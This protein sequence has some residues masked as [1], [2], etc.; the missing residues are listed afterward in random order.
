MVVERCLIGAPSFCPNAVTYFYLSGSSPIR[1]NMLEM[2][3]P[4]NL[5]VPRRLDI[6]L[7]PCC[8][9]N[10]ELRGTKLMKQLHLRCRRQ[11]D[12][13]VVPAGH[14]FLGAL[15]EHFDF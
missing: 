11:R 3:H 10:V 5:T 7:Q 15:R 2:T 6:V 1:S 13:R 12:E 9:R 4:L 14:V 8:Y